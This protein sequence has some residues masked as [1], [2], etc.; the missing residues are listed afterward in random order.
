VVTG[1]SAGGHLALMT[2]LLSDSAGF[3]NHCFADDDQ[4]WTGK[5][6]DAPKVAA[7]I[8]WFGPTDMVEMVGERRSFAVSWIENPLTMQELARRVSPITYV[9]SGVP[10]VLT[11]HGDGD[12]LVPYSQAVRLHA[13][14]EKVGVRNQLITIAGGKHGDFAEPQLLKAYEAIQTFLQRLGLTPAVTQ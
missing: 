4:P 1:A 6:P 14:L 8:N 3:D 9:R 5:I 2:G 13:A 12:P 10:P 7:V 11:V